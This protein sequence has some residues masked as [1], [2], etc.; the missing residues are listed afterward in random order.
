MN[1]IAYVVGEVDD[2]GRVVNVGVYSESHPTICGPVLLV[3]LTLCHGRDFEHAMYNAFEWLH[4]TAADH[5]WLKPYLKRFVDSHQDLIARE[6]A[7]LT[8]RPSSRSL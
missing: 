5:S 2:D 3:Q 6:Y 4:S 8:A 7:R 1:T